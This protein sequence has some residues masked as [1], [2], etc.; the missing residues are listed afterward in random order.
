MLQQTQVSR[1][2]PAWESFLDALP[3]PEAAARA[4]QAAIVRRWEGMGY[5]RRAVALH[6]CATQIVE[7]HGGVVPSSLEQLEALAGIGPYTA[8]AVQAFAFEVDAAV[9]DTNVARIISRAVTGEPLRAKETQQIA[10]LLVPPG[11]AWRHNQAMLD[12]G[13]LTCRPTP[14]C[15]DCTLRRSCAW[16]RSGFASPD[17]A[18]TTAGTSR[19]QGRFEGSDRQ[20][21]GL[22]LDAARKER[23]D[24][25]WSAEL[26]ERF[27]AERV[28]QQTQVMIAE[29]LIVRRASGLRLA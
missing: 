4:G 27:G 13:A 2:I 5:H 26:D 10:D 17:P 22:I 8:R 21:R 25:A 7:R 28:A 1:V 19:P 11:E 6:R 15:G 20:L 18:R 24:P 3:T 9:V 23:T 16:A 14:Q 12:H 29:G